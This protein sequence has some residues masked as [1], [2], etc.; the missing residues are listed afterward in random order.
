MS[1]AFLNKPIGGSKKDA[2]GEP[3][4]PVKGRAPGPVRGGAASNISVGGSPRADLMPPEIR[5][6]RSQLRT[7]R[8]LRLALFGVFLLVIVA[9][10]GAWAWSA[11]AQTA[12]ASAQSQQQALVAQQTK[13]SKVTTLQNAITLIQ[14]GQ[15]IG[16]ATE[17]DWQDYL[18]KLQATLPAGVSLSTVSI[19]TADPMTAYAQSTTPLEGDRIATLTFTATSPSLPSIPVWLD[20]LKTLPGFVDATP[21]QVSLSS[22]VYSADVTMH[23]GTDAFAHRFDPKKKDA[24]TGSSDTSTGGGN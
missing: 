8:S 3:E 18:T 16:D 24:S 14:A 5:L 10:G 13:Y 7:R 9:C 12:L 23:I 22:G 20:G 21:G 15:V 2:A 6:K 1:L 17:I 11:I 19:G 4:K